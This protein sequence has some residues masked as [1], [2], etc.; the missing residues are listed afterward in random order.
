MY[1]S[2]FL[3]FLDSLVTSL[4]LKVTRAPAAVEV[5]IA[6]SPGAGCPCTD[7]YC[8]HEES[9]NS[10]SSFNSN[11]F[12]AYKLHVHRSLGFNSNTILGFQLQGKLGN[13]QIGTKVEL[14]KERRGLWRAPKPSFTLQLGLRTQALK[15][16]SNFPDIVPPSPRPPR[17]GYS[18]K[19]GVMY[20]L[21][22]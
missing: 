4:A 1:T 13:S 5:T 22:T 3:A 17:G 2:H 10:V 16:R 11:T 12:L 14:E 9:K 15:G 8:T 18:H 21:D 19:E 7:R 6:T 20:Q